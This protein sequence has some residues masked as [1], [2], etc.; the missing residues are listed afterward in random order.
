MNPQLSSLSSYSFDHLLGEG[1]SGEVWKVHKA[2]Q[3]AAVKFYHEGK[4]AEG[5]QELE[6]LKKLEHPHIVK[7]MEVGQWEGH[8]YLLMEYVEGRSLMEIDPSVLTKDN[9]R[10]IVGQLADAIAYAHRQG[11]IHRDLKPANIILTAEGNIKILDFGVAAPI[12][13]DPNLRVIE[14]S[15]LYMSPEQLAGKINFQN[16]IWA[17]GTLLYEWLTGQHPYEAKTLGEL[18]QQLLILDVEYPHLLNPAIP[19]E[20]SYIL[21]KSLQR[22]LK[23]RY[24]NMDDLLQDL[25]G[26]PTAVYREQMQGVDI[27]RLKTKKYIP[28]S[29]VR[30]ILEICSIFVLLVILEGIYYLQDSSF[31]LF[32]TEDQDPSFWDIILLLGFVGYAFS[33]LGRFFKQLTTMKPKG[34]ETQDKALALG[35]YLPRDRYAE[36]IQGLILFYNLSQLNYKLLTYYARTEKWRWLKQRIRSLL[37]TDPDNV[38]AL[39]LQ[40]YT[41]AQQKAWK[42]AAASCQQILRVNPDDAVGLFYNKVLS[43]Q[44][45][46]TPQASPSRTQIAATIVRPKPDV[47]VSS[48]HSES[49][50]QK[51][52][53]ENGKVR[54]PIE[55]IWD[56]FTPITGEGSLTLYDEYCQIRVEKVKNSEHP[57]LIRERLRSIRRIGGKNQRIAIGKQKYYKGLYVTD[58]TDPKYAKSGLRDIQSAHSLMTYMQKLPI[59]QS[60]AEDE[61][62]ASYT[63][64]YSQI[65][66]MAL[67]GKWWEV[68]EIGLLGIEFPDGHVPANLIPWLKKKSGKTVWTDAAKEDASI[69]IN[70]LQVVNLLGKFFLGIFVLLFLIWLRYGGRL[71]DPEIREEWWIA[72]SVIG[73]VGL[74]L[75]V[76]AYLKTGLGY[77]A[78]RE[79]Q[80]FGKK[81]KWL[82][83]TKVDS[84][85]LE[86][87]EDNSFL[88]CTR[89]LFQ[90][91]QI[92]PVLNKPKI[93]VRP[94]KTITAG[95]FRLNYPNQQLLIASTPLK[96]IPF[97][98]VSEIIFSP[99]MIRIKQGEHIFHEEPLDVNHF[100]QYLPHLLRIFKSRIRI[101]N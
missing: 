11:L 68:A 69:G 49:S 92:F 80:Y 2:D 20:I 81:V 73:I 48:E 63:I 60:Q 35:F 67:E 28:F 64:P 57:V 94:K 50:L 82:F 78:W 24:A 47:Q 42:K 4:L 65:N 54:I 77:G 19:E 7:G 39:S 25:T 98:A 34:I 33:I 88:E 101:A 96:T 56:N 71:S 17:F 61:L 38:A 40:I 10:K 79:I 46:P 91:S 31:L 16:D 12:S 15:Y 95:P 84:V 43:P 62:L 53:A 3:V 27:E 100:S 51:Q 32:E 45:S 87:Q 74:V 13:Y 93:Q 6:L 75:G 36:I 59:L 90:A 72:V 5:L 55:L 85:W 52:I 70:W 97:S 1:T 21:H 41:H 76:Q 89:L 66:R 18:G 9:L 37:K 83:N 29:P 22:D 30:L 8:P 44:S 58:Y 26:D 14:G 99:Q 86:E 23:D